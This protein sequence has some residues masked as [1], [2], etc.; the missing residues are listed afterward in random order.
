[1]EEAKEAE[2]AKETEEAAKE[3]QEATQTAVTKNKS[4][5]SQA[6]KV[7]N[8]IGKLPESAEEEEVFRNKMAHKRS[9]LARSA[10]EVQQL[11]KQDFGVGRGAQL[12]APAPPAFGLLPSS[13]G[14]LFIPPFASPLPR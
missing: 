4:A 2:E 7:V 10:V 9:S 3:A 11:L 1:M 5:V 8:K 13:L 12:F 14:A 6:L